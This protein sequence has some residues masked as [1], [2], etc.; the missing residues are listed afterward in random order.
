MNLATALLL[1]ASLQDVPPVEDP[2]VTAPPPPAKITLTTGEVL[3]A[4]VVEETPG[5]YK[6]QHPVLG[7]I[8]LERTDVT[9]VETPSLEPEAPKSPWSGSISFAIA[10]YD[11]VNSN[12]EL[13]VGGELKR[14]TDVDE[15]TITARYFFG[16]Q[17]AQTQN[18]NFLATVDYRRDLENKLWYVFG[19]GQFQY[20]EFQSWEQRLSAW[21]GIG[22]WFV[23]EEQ[24][25]VNARIGFGVSYEFGPDRVLP[26]ALAGVEVEWRPT[27]NNKLVAFFTFFPDVGDIQ[28]FRFTTGAKWVMKIEG[29]DGLA[30]EAGVSDDY[31]SQITSGTRNDFR[32]FAGLKYDF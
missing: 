21:G 20:D 27:K 6:V 2:S 11:N 24:L 19:T 5:S 25:D 9:S 26:E 4:V 15:L 10:G 22:H 12:V 30:F 32:Y 23:K 13:R 16:V 31:Q 17:N 14:K 28:E 18:N 3:E 7:E 1:G 29:V 8:I